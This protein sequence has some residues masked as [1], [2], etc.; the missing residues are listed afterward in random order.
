MLIY[1]YIYSRLAPE[2]SLSAFMIDHSFRY[3]LSTSF[4]GLTFTIELEPS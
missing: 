4:I 3:L 2:D 1:I